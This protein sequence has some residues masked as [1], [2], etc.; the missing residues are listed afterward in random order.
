MSSPEWARAVADPDERCWLLIEG[1]CEHLHPLGPVIV[2]SV[3]RLRESVDRPERN[4]EIRRDFDGHNYLALA[5]KHRISQRQV[6]R[7]V[8]DPRAPKRPQ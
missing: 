4:D 6:R 5:R 3:H 2:P 8:D 1:L 7:V